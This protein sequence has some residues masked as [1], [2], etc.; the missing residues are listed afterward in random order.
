[1]DKKPGIFARRFFRW[2][3]AAMDAAGVSVRELATCAGVSEGAIRAA[4]K[5][6][7]TTFATAGKLIVALGEI[8]KATGCA[9]PALRLQD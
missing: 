8:E 4:I 7:N 2:L 3:A 1:M 5:S 9:L 6:Q